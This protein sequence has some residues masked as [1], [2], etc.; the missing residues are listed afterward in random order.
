MNQILTDFQN[1]LL[2]RKL[3]ANYYN[4]V[5]LWFAYLEKNNIDY[6]KFTQNDI[7]NFINAN[8]DYQKSTLTQFVKANRFFYGKFLNIKDNEWEK[9]PY[10][11]GHKT[12]PKFLSIDDLNEIISKFCTFENRLM[13]PYKTE[14]F[15]KFV[16]FTGLR[17]AEIISLKRDAF[18]FETNPVEIRVIGKGDKFRIVY[19][20]EKYSPKLRQMIIDYFSSEPQKTNAFN[21][22]KGQINYMFKKMNKYCKEKHVSPHIFRHCVT[23]DTQ[24]FT[25]KGWKPFEKLNIKEKIM[26]Y[27]LKKNILEYKSIIKIHQYNIKEKIYHLKTSGIDTM[28]TKEHRIIMQNW[29]HI[30][31]KNQWTDKMINPISSITNPFRYIISSQ[32]KET[33]DKIGIHKAFILG[34]LMADGCINYYVT[35]YRGIKKTYYYNNRGIVISQSWSANKIKCRMIKYHLK[36]SKIGFT[37]HIGK[38]IIGNFGKNYQM[39]TFRIL[40]DYQDWIFKWLNKNKM[41]KNSIYQLSK[42]ELEYLFKG[43]ILG[44]GCKQKCNCI[45]FRGQEPEIIELLQT[46]CGLLGFRSTLATDDRGYFRLYICKRNYRQLDSINLKK[47][48]KTI[49]YTGVV[50]C[51]ETKNGTFLAKRNNSVF[52][53]GNSY[54]KYMLDKSVPITF[55][56][57]LLGHSSLTSTMLYINP[58]DEQIKKAFK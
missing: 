43:L 18:N 4:V 8:P 21:I 40:T 19:I 38:K 29:K 15:I 10:Y 45:E 22:T 42:R 57:R 33:K 12:T 13:N 17:K 1:H 25:K 56:Q 47:S 58:T 31:G 46:I 41:P 7:T 16:Y 14:V 36:K 6:L 53:T 51:P 11:K 26:T 50:W 44:D 24:A 30:K 5:K 52:L 54:A 28:F 9:I 39:K 20:S 49:D 27:N 35:K 34:I 37:E 55:I 32:I 23:A 2:A 3:S 48:L